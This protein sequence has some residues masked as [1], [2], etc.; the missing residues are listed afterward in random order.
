M[1]P[2][3]SLVIARHLDELRAESANRRLV[4]TPPWPEEASTPKAPRRSRWAIF[5]D[6]TAVL[7]T[8]RNY[9]YTTR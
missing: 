8:L 2:L 3:K 1:Y 6:P 9:P 5:D 4:R 7:P